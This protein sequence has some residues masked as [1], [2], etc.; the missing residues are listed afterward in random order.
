MWCT[1]DIVETVKPQFVIWEN[2]KNLLSK[3]HIHN[4]N[5][6][7]E[8]MEQLGYNSY[9]QVLNAKDYG[10]PQNRER[11]YTISIRKDIDTGNFSFPD[12]QKLNIRLKDI[13]EDSVPDKFYLSDKMVQGFQEHNK[14][15]NDKGTGFIWKTRDTNGIA[16]TLR[17]NSAL[18]PT[19][20]T[21][22][23][24][25]ISKNSQACQVYSDEGVS[26]TIMAGTHGYAIGNIIQPNSVDEKFYL[27]EEQVNKIENSSFV[28]ER[29]RIQNTDI[30][31]TLL[32]RDYKDPKCV[33]V[34]G[35][36]DNENA[37]HQ[38]GS[39]YDKDGLAPPIDTMQGGYRQPM[40]TIDNP[41]KGKSNYGWHFEQNVY[42]ENSQ[43]CRSVKA[44]GGSGNI[45]KI[46]TVGN[47]RHDASRIVDEKGLAPTVK[48]NH[49]TVTAVLQNQKETNNISVENKIIYEEPLKRKGW[50]RK[51][52]EFLNPDGISTCIHTQSNNLLQKI[53]VEE[54]F[55]T[56]AIETCKEKNCNNG[57]T[58]D[59]FNKK[60]NTSGISP[61]ITT[62]PEGFKTAILPIQNY[63]IRKL[64]PK[65]CWRLMRI[66]R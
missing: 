44:G 63:R 55:F 66:Y 10:I 12:K 38:A 7:L 36:F 37:K 64:T 35:M 49:G 28:Q 27:T 20:N 31:D 50:H 39:V 30:C 51:A 42:G 8:I 65:E 26:P 23:V 59:A 3:K 43:C 6:Y 45:P 52:C 25:E 9:Y 32:A 16:S 56:Q 34:G 54:R 4:F 21:I 48:E 18:C 47:Y 19:D 40:V 33:R 29:K 13:L 57:D 11:V 24:G 60:V 62:R 2:V 46:I 14:N 41:L 15:H 17:A 53:K 5:N 61:T 22:N 1:V 58:I